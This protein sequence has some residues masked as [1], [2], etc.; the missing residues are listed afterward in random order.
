MF[1]ACVKIIPE[2]SR[3]F[4]PRQY[5]HSRNQALYTNVPVLSIYDELSKKRARSQIVVHVL[6]IYLRN[7]SA[8]KK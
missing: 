3:G 4:T 8:S 1:N 2:E 6:N 5:N 7:I